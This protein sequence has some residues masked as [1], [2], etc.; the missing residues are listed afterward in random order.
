MNT[1]KVGLIGLG[2]V[3][4][5]FYNIAKNRKEFQIT[6]VLNRSEK[7]YAIYHVPNKTIANDLL[8][9]IKEVDLVVETVGGID[10][11]S[12]VISL[13]LNNGKDVV[14][15]NK[16]LIAAKGDELLDLAK[17]IGR[18]L[19]FGASVGGGMPVLQNIQYHSMGKITRIYG[20]LNATSNFVLSKM[21][22]GLS[23]SQAIKIAQEK[24]YAEQDPSDDISGMDAAQ[25]LAIVCAYITGK[26][27]DLKDISVYPLQ[28]NQEQMSYIK[29][30]KMVVKPL[31]YMNIKDDKIGLWVG[32]AAVAQNSKV[33]QIEGTENCLI[34]EGESGINSLTGIGAGQNP[35]AFAVMTDVMSIAKGNA[36]LL[37]FKKDRNLN[38]FEPNFKEVKGVKI[39]DV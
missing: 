22:E 29:D 8:D 38:I 30:A 14:T 35:T 37:H 9:L 3:G 34:V 2:T 25:K 32:P 27:P 11:P 28:I 17:K 15:A 23:M 13:A 31:I 36:T 39:I 1:V 18:K 16:A 21:S 26:L 7:K 33:A 20:I 4:G 12:E 24:G 6:K 19:L 5:G 10:F